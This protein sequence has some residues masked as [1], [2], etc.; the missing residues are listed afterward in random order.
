MILTFGPFNME[1]VS[2]E[3]QHK[4]L[5]K[6]LIENGFLIGGKLVENKNVSEKIKEEII[7]SV[8]Y[9]NYRN[10]Y[11]EGNIRS[12]EKDGKPYL[13]RKEFLD[14]IGADESWGIYSGDSERVGVIGNKDIYDLQDTE[15]YRYFTELF[16]DDSNLEKESGTK[17]KVKVENGSKVIIYSKESEDEKTE[18]NI[19]ELEN[20][21]T[22]DLKNEIENGNEWI[23]KVPKEKLTFKGESGSVKYKVEFKEIKLSN[24]G[25]STDSI[26]LLYFIP[27]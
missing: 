3:S 17:Y 9:F 6:L 7:N 20:K 16:I 11:H 25:K 5:E 2:I 4:R 21:V 24:N 12:F 1:K 8:S 13:T 15:E 23:L 19:R 27:K 10:N 18:I 26:I 22:D 14:K